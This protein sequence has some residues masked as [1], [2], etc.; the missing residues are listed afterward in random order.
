MV[1][2][3]NRRPT[4]RSTAPASERLADPTRSVADIPAPDEFSLGIIFGVYAAAYA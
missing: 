3:A 2:L 4:S 1:A